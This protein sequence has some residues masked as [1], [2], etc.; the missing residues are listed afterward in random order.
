MDKLIWLLFS[1]NLL[2]QATSSL[3]G[4]FFPI[5]AKDERGVSSFLVG[6]SMSMNSFSFVIFSYIIGHYILWIGRRTSI[7]LGLGLTAVTM[8]GFGLIYW[9][10][11]KSWF[12]GSALFLRFVAGIGQALVTVASYSIAAIK[13]K[14]TLH[15][16]V[17]LLEAGNGAGFFLGP[18]A[19]GIIYEF[20]HF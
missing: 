3:F 16:K 10:E 7:H 18:V 6:A 14:D 11:D 15:Q 19:G 8:V 20:T 17:G 13:Y 1:A 4:P 12:I 2:F 9:I 5:V